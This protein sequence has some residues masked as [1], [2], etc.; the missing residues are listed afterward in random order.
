MIIPLDLLLQDHINIYELT[1][2]IIRRSYQ[3]SVTGDE[4]LETNG[5]KIVP[6]AIRQIL[7]GRVQ[8]RVE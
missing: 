5:G 4:E 1:S 8:Y 6:T 7:T 3:I 2:A